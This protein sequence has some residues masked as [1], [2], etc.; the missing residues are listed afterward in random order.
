MFHCTQ[1]EQCCDLHHTFYAISCFLGGGGI[2]IMFMF[3]R[4]LHINSPNIVI[5]FFPNFSNFI[6]VVTCEDCVD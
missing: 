6:G 1:F 4:L 3:L 2:C 5:S